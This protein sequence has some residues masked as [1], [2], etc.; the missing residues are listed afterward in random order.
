MMMRRSEARCNAERA[1]QRCRPRG[2][3]GGDVGRDDLLRRRGRHTKVQTKVRNRALF[4]RS[5][6]GDKDRVVMLPRSLA[7]SLRKHVAHETQPPWAANVEA[8]RAGKQL[9]DA[10]AREYP[11]AG[12]SWFW[13]RVSAHQRLSIL[14]HSGVIRRH[15]LHP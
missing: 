13:F 10:L 15:D 2:C 14:P 7:P 5:A 1:C 3:R 9:R 8:G 12:A 11:R 6:K 4:V